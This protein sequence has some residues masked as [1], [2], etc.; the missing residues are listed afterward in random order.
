MREKEARKERKLVNGP[1][2]SEN[3]REGRKKQTFYVRT[4][5]AKCVI[6]VEQPVLLL[7]YYLLTLTLTLTC[8]LLVLF[9]CC[10]SSLMSFQMRCLVDCYF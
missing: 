6:A 10:R 5:V 4:R 8:C 1:V 7:R 3:K 9:P 2:V